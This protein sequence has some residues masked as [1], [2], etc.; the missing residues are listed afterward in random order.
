[1]VNKRK[2]ERLVGRAERQL[3]REGT[4][5]EHRGVVLTTDDG[6]RLLLQRIGGNP[7]ADGETQKLAG[8]P[9]AVE[10]FRL[11][12]IF[13]YTHAEVAEED[14]SETPASSSPDS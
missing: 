10:G 1:M 12:D 5:S 2:L 3:I 13:R 8:K 9:L 11:D 6:E 7:F 14:S 4:A